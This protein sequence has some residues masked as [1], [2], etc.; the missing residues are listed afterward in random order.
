MR[1]SLVAVVCG[2]VVLASACTGPSPTPGTRAGVGQRTLAVNIS[3][4][5]VPAPGAII[6]S[7]QIT[8]GSQTVTYNGSNTI[9]SITGS[10]STAD[11][12]FDVSLQAVGTSYNGTVHFAA[13]TF[14]GGSFDHVW[15]A[16]FAPLSV[17]GDN[18]ISG[19]LND[20]AGTLIEFSITTEDTAGIEAAYDTLAGDETD[21]CAEAQQS[22]AGLDPAQVPVSSIT[23]NH[24]DNRASFGGSKSSL[25]PLTTQT[26]QTPGEFDTAAGN[27]LAVTDSISCKTRSEDHLATTGVTTSGSDAQ[28]STLN[29]ASAARAFALL[30]P[31]EQTAYAATGKTLAFGP[32][33][34]N[35]TGT[36]WL[37]PIIDTTLVG[38]TM[39]VTAHALL[40]RWTDPA[41]AIFP[42]TI[43]GVHYC[44]VKSPSWFYW[45]YTAGS[46]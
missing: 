16:N 32:D 38:N 37:A 29:V 44:T 13:P 39:T 24:Y 45:W 21:F 10:V 1:K 35:Q 20:G 11:W 3:G 5:G 40:V 36:E 25:S 46:N 12:A 28:C 27:N 41:F 15:A 31:A 23:N 17:D 4:P 30:T 26:Y 2:V 34:I 19:T 8:A 43:R 7:E 22:L 18:D 33:L 14:V 42:D 6:G 9:S